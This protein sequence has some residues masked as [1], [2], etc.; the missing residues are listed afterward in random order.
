MDLYTCGNGNLIKVL[1]RVERMFGIHPL[2]LPE[3]AETLWSLKLR[4]FRERSFENLDR[5]FGESIASKRHIELKKNVV[6]EETEYQQLDVYEILDPK[7][8]ESTSLYK[9]SLSNDG[10]YESLHPEHFRPNRYVYLDG[11]VQSTLMGEG[12]YHEGM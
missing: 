6:S 5:D 8:H 10:S 3:P 4:G 2:S 9:K 11:Q 1:P 7:F 12:S